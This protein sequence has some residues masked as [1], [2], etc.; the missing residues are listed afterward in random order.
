MKIFGKQLVGILLAM[1]AGAAQG[2]WADSNVTTEADLLEAVN[3]SQTVTL[4]AD[5]TTPSQNGRLDISSGV[6]VTLDLN[7]HTLTRPMTAADDGGQVIFVANGGKLTIT[8]SSN[9]KKGKITGGWAYQGGGIYVQSGGELTINGGTITGNRADKKGDG[10]GFGG[11][12]ENHGTLTIT[13][14]VITGNTA[15]QFGGGIHNE[16]TLNIT[17]GSITDNTAGTYGG[18][19]YSNSTV[20]ISGVT[21]SGNSAQQG[22]GAISSEGETSLSNVTITGNSSNHYGGGIYMFGTGTVQMSGD[23]TIT[24]NIAQAGGGIFHV[25]N[26]AGVAGP[27]LKMQDKP[28]VDNNS[29]NDVYLQSYQLITVTGAFTEGTRIGVDTEIVQ[30]VFT[31]G[32]GKYHKWEMTNPDKFFFVSNPVLNGTI[33]TKTTDNTSEAYLTHTTYKAIKYIER[34]WDNEAKKVADEEKTCTSY[35]PISGNDTGDN[36]WFGLDNGWYVVTGNSSYKTLN[37]TGTD[38]HLIIPDGATLTVTG[39]VKVEQGHKLTIYGQTH[40]TGRL[41]ANSSAYESAAGIG[42]GINAKAGDVTIHGGTIQATGNVGSTGIGTGGP[43]QRHHVKN[44]GGTVVIYGG[45]V[46]ATG[47]GGGAGIGGGAELDLGSTFHFYMYGGTVTA[48]GGSYGG[49]GIGGGGNGGGAYGKVEGST[50]DIYGGTLTATG[51]YNNYSHLSG[52]GIGGGDGGDSGMKVHIHGGI[53]T[54]QCGSFDGDGKRAIGPGDGGD[55]YGELTIADDLMVSAGYSVADS[56]PFDAGLRVSGC[57]YRP[58][59]VIAPCTHPNPTY[60]VSGTSSTDTHLK[61]CAYCLTPFEA[62]R[63]TFVNGKCTVCGVELTTYQVTVNVPKDNGAVDG[64]YEPFTY[65]MVPGTTFKLPASPITF[66]DRVFAGWLVGTPSNNSY[67]V[68]DGEELLAAGEEYTITGNVTFSARYSYIYIQLNDNADN[69]ETLSKYVGMTATQVIL[70]DRTLYKDGAW[71]TLC[72]PFDVAL[73][74]SPLK[75]ATVKTLESASFANGTLTLTFSDDLTAIEAGKP[76][77]VKW[78]AQSPSTVENPAFTGVTISTATADVETNEV[79]FKGIFSPKEIAGTDNTLL[80]L[81]ADNKLYYPSAAM[82]IGACRA[83]FQLADGITA[84]DPASGIRS[85]VL[86][87]GDET[88][89]INNGQWSTVNGQSEGWFTLDGRCLT[90]KPSAKGLYIY[91]GKKI[92]I[93]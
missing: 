5:I 65:Q 14:G 27:T 47:G 53:V 64:V 45:N 92:V 93:K 6:N 34:S 82:T 66:S 86:N 70:K 50:V 23:C 37:V 33:G 8:D 25:S 56:A 87:F 71:N 39:G 22:G 73:E 58:Y 24:G 88:M 41:I 10:Y 18:A 60:T 3:T 38:A 90:G 54:A 72:L 83:Y 49:A 16:G 19:I 17:G 13:G 15:G 29:P 21:I 51:G 68:S 62:E 69:S 75:G 78:T 76:Y 67:R 42:S 40:D 11:G 59:A 30:D 84:G 9:D 43:P 20:S 91:N 46:T 32:Y 26:G 2:A 1:M 36:G 74:A 89:G 81:G 35:T 28:V 80:Y 4:E 7:G 79:T 85:F 77:I 52:A 12:I 63:H 44:G 48:Q 55:D 31:T 61:H 57:W